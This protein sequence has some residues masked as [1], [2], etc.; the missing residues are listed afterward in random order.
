MRVLV[1]GAAG[2]VG[3]SLVRA[4][5]ARGDE[6]VATD[7]NAMDA[8]AP[9][10]ER[11]GDLL[12]AAFV[13]TLFGRPFDLVVHAAAS[14]PLAGRSDRD[15][16]TNVTATRLLAR[17][18]RGSGF[19]V[20]IGSS[21]VWGRP[22]EI[23]TSATPYAPFEA[24]GR[25]KLEAERVLAAELAGSSTRFAVVRPRTIVGSGRGGLFEVLIRWIRAGLPIPLAGGGRARLGLVG[26][27]DL[28][29]LVL[30]LADRRIEG[31]WPA[32]APGVRPLADEI[33][34]LIVR[35]KSESFTFAVPGPLLSAVGRLLF[36]LRL[37]P[38]RPW[39]VGGWSSPQFLVDERWKP[40]GF[41][42][43]KSNG[44]LLT[45]LLDG[46]VERDGSPHRSGLAT[47]IVDRILRLARP[48]ARLTRVR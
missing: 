7:R 23:V 46:A 27:D 42:Y 28:V 43:A 6:V 24:Y 13:S 36:A 48:I 39:H 14:V 26:I 30:H 32:A 25:S 17:A 29:A 47:P 19:L 3:A 1:T 8:G 22:R 16:R 9:V 40:D 41:V 20:L 37:A 5:V 2:Y 18:A 35:A 10:E 12:D 4:L 38:F 31:I 44:E 11:V 33:G 34:A 45:E 15:Y 21:A